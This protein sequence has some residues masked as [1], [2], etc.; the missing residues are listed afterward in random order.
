MQYMSPAKRPGLRAL[1]R[2]S[3]EGRLLGVV[4]ATTQADELRVSTSRIDKA[5]GVTDRECQGGAQD[6]KWV[7]ESTWNYIAKFI[8]EVPRGHGVLNLLARA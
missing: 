4:A 6:W 2:T 3:V 1:L 7:L 5:F 8:V